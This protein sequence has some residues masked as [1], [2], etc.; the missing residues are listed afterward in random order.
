MRDRRIDAKMKTKVAKIHTK[1]IPKPE[2]GIVYG[3]NTNFYTQR[4]SSGSKRSRM[5]IFRKLHAATSLYPYLCFV[6]I[7]LQ[8]SIMKNFEFFGIRANF[9]GL[10]DHLG[11][12][13]AVLGA[14]SRGSPSRKSSK[15]F[16][17][18]K[19]VQ[20]VFR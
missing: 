19:R 12:V 16:E 17:G 11:P 5:K 20:N 4:R 2:N 18:S 9:T 8:I 10:R 14:G 7:R 3:P 1:A 13:A 6:K 15:I